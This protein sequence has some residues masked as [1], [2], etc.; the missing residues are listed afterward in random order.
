MPAGS[1]EDPMKANKWQ[2]LCLWC[3]YGLLAVGVAGFWFH[4]SE[5]PAILGKYSREYLL[6][7]CLVTAGGAAA[8]FA[9]WLV[10]TPQ[11]LVLRSGRT[12]TPSLRA[13]LLGVVALAALVLVVAEIGLT[14]WEARKWGPRQDL[15]GF[16]PFLQNVPVAGNPA[17]P[18][19]R[20]GFRGEDI[21]LAKPGGTYRIFVLGGSTVY[22]REVGFEQTHCRLQEKRVR[23]AYPHVKVE[24]QNAGCPWH[25]SQHSLIKFLT[26]VEDFDPDL[27]IVYHGLNDLVRGFTPPY[28]TRGDYQPDYGHYLGPA[29]TLVHSYAEDRGRFHLY[30]VDEARTFLDRRWFSD[31]RGTGEHT[32]PVRETAITEWKSLPSFARNMRNLAA[33][34]R[35]KGI[36]LILASQPYLYKEGMTAQERSAAGA[37][38]ASRYETADVPS[39][40][41]G[42][43]K[44][45]GTSRAVA[46]EHG[47]VFVD[48]EKRVPKTLDY[49]V[50]AFHYTPEG[51][52]VVGEALGEAVIANGFVDRKFP[53]PSP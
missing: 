3:L 37:I 39:M 25:T 14:R 13:K 44:F 53:R 35:S 23:R 4:T 2:R 29:A 1:T 7:A 46:R 33:A 21:E 26:K 27:V 43:E 50:D 51:N 22:C 34:V 17:P 31:L 28:V 11:Q 40:I 16:H 36:G 45:N 6:V 32:P 38:Q 10:L 47:V 8:G 30:V 24:V 49:F 18:I 9:A 52:R 5:M 19:N 12:I 42:M 48:L 20:W 15:A 41:C